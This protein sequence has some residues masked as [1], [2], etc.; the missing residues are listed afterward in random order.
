MHTFQIG[1]GRQCRKP[2]ISLCAFTSVRENGEGVLG[3]GKKNGI[4]FQLKPVAG[5]LMKNKCLGHWSWVAQQLEERECS[6]LACKWASLHGVI[7][8]GK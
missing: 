7:R 4:L 6:P 5:L 8:V 1:L 2:D 3:L